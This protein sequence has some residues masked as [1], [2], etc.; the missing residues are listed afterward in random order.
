MSASRGSDLR[1]MD[2]AARHSPL[3]AGATSPS[4][5][6]PIV[7]FPDPYGPVT[8]IAWPRLPPLMPAPSLAATSSVPAPGM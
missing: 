8:D 5:K 2:P 4:R 7:D 6:T 1:S 3:L